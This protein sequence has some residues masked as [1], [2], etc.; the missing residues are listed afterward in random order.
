[1]FVR[2]LG[3]L[4]TVVWIT[5]HLFDSVSIGDQLLNTVIHILLFS[6]EE[7][8]RAAWFQDLLHDLYLRLN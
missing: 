2:R 7:T 6:V 3:K 4:S 5:T 1:M 8:I